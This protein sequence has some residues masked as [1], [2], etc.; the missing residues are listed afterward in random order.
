MPPLDESRRFGERR[1]DDDAPVNDGHAC[2][3]QRHNCADCPPDVTALERAVR[4]GCGHGGAGVAEEPG[5]AGGVGGYG[6]D[7]DGNR[8]E[9][10]DADTV[11]VWCRGSDGAHGGQPGGSCRSFHRPSAA[12][13]QAAA[14]TLCTPPWAVFRPRATTAGPTVELLACSSPSPAT[15]PVRGVGGEPECRPGIYAG[16]RRRGLPVPRG[17]AQG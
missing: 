11:A 16:E 9:A 2:A 7:G 3:A 4:L 1:E 6:G 5:G 8:P 14:A 17:R 12:P 10:L 15:S 13:R